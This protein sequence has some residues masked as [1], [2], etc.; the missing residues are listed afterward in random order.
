VG[1]SKKCSQDVWRGIGGKEGSKIFS[2][3]PSLLSG[4]AHRPKKAVN[5]RGMKN[6]CSGI[7]RIR[8][9]SPCSITA[10]ARKLAGL[11]SPHLHAWVAWSYHPLAPYIEFRNADTSLTTIHYAVHSVD[12]SRCYFAFQETLSASLSC[13]R[14]DN[15]R[16]TKSAQSICKLSELL[17]RQC[18]AP[19][20]FYTPTD[21]SLFLFRRHLK[22]WK[23]I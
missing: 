13:W 1:G 18:S 20:C 15:L 7:I 2:C 8:L 12:L 16:R 23:L 17:F 3:F 11:L 14:R 9:Q 6:V 22:L 5:A 4:W 19:S 21:R 10:W